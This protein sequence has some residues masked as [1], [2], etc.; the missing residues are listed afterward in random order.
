MRSLPAA[1][2]S[3]VTFSRVI[4]FVL[5]GVE[6]AELRIFF[7]V[8]HYF[9]LLLEIWPHYSS[10]NVDPAVTCQRFSAEA[11]LCALGAV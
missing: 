5:L 2:Q 4:V 9:S 11:S 10:A 6:K 3:R 8:I 7:G 1:P